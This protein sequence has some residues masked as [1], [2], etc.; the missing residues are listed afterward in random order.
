MELFQPSR[1]A[2]APAQMFLVIRR[3]NLI[4]TCSWGNNNLICNNNN[5]GVNLVEFR[6]AEGCRLGW[7]KRLGR[8]QFQSNCDP[9]SGLVLPA[10]MSF[11]CGKLK[12]EWVSK[13]RLT[14]ICQQQQPGGPVFVTEVVTAGGQLQDD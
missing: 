6:I 11:C 10:C 14:K 13:D 12:L 7:R 2:F 3:V 4:W 5:T 8:G 9:E 1:Q